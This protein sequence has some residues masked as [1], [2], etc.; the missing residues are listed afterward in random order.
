[1]RDDSRL[2]NTLRDTTGNVT[3]ASEEQSSVI[4]RVGTLRIERGFRLS[5]WS[6]SYLRSSGTLRRVD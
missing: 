5:P 2:L 6:K 4:F 1:M 3:G